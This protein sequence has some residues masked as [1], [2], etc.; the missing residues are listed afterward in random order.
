MT[1]IDIGESKTENLD[2]RAPA[3][4]ADLRAGVLDIVLY[5]V[6]DPNWVLGGALSTSV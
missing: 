2:E 3:S 6:D 4:I 1:R 5:D